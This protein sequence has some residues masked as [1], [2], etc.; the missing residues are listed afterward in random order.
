MVIARLKASY[1]QLWFVQQKRV[2]LGENMRLLGSIESLTLARYRS[3]S[4]LQTD[5]LTAQMERTKIENELLVNRQEELSAKA[6]LMALLNRAPADTIGYARVSEEVTFDANLDTLLALAV[7]LRPMLVHDSLSVREQETERSLARQG[8]LPDVNLGLQYVTSPMTGFTG[9]GI[10]AGITLPFA[11]WTLGRTGAEV[12]KADAMLTTARA[13]YTAAKAMVLSTVRD[14]YYQAGARK[15]ALDNYR[16][17]VIPQAEQ[18]LESSTRSYEAGKMDFV[19]LLEAYQRRL[20]AVTE[21]FQLRLEFERFMAELDL[22][23]GLQ[24]AAIRQ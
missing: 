17:K 21:Y 24:D 11:P 4:A 2:L 7:G 19:M 8:Y 9:W 14:K 18:I 5:V 15:A 13:R 3:G 23:V 1:L 10:S 6:E 22:A 16:R 20:A 12:D